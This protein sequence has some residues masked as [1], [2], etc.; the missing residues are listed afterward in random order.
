[1]LY[2]KAAATPSR[3]SD[4]IKHP[5]LHEQYINGCGK[6]RPLKVPSADGESCSVL[7]PRMHIEYKLNRNNATNGTVVIV[8]THELECSRGESVRSSSCHVGNIDVEYVFG[9]LR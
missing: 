5:A 2:Y 4:E 6:N 3:F 9:C 1:M 8:D 7:L